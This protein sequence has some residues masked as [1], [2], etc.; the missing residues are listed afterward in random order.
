MVRHRGDAAGRASPLV[1]RLV[2]IN[3]FIVQEI[4]LRVKTHHLAARSEAWVDAH[5][6]ALSQRSRQKQLFEVFCKDKDGFVVGF[7]FRRCRK[8]VFDAWTQETLI[9]I[10]QGQLHLRCGRRARFHV[11]A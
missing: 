7:L 4:S 10:R 3:R 8:F 6:A 11:M 2:G 5:D 9:G 1:L